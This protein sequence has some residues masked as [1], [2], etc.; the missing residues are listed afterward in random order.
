MGEIFSNTMMN[1][2]INNYFT[3]YITNSMIEDIVSLCASTIPDFYQ[4]ET[5]EISYYVANYLVK[6]QSYDDF[7][8]DILK[9]MTT[10]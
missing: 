3:N 8:N 2:I 6:D 5:E 7:Y 10:L 9:K 1:D 4:M